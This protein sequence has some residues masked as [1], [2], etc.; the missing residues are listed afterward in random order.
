MDKN[1]I[2]KFSQYAR[3]TLIPEMEQAISIWKNANIVQG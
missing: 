3:S 2:K 1:Q